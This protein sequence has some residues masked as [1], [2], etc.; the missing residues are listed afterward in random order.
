MLMKPSRIAS[1]PT[2]AVLLAGLAVL[3]SAA[4]WLVFI[5]AKPAAPEPA[6]HPSEPS[7]KIRMITFDRPFPPEGRFVA[8]PYV[9]SRV[10]AECHPAESAVH[11][12]SGH[13]R[14]LQ[15]AGRL[16]ISRQLD[17]TKQPDPEI[18]GVMWSYTYEKGEL[19]IT[20]TAAS[21]IQ[22]WIA[23]YAIG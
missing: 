18:D 23:D 11:S 22:Q 4:A 3:G 5:T 13:A 15:P 7:K 16:K 21:E 1:W 9:G 19:H 2:I 14:T 17:G 12:R 10:C 8:D 20:R 6:R